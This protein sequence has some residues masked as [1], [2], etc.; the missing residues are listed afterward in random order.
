MSLSPADIISSANYAKAKKEFLSQTVETF[1]EKHKAW[2]L[3]DK[4]T[5]TGKKT[6]EDI[7]LGTSG[8]A[9][10]H[11]P[12]TRLPSASLDSETRLISLEDK[13]T[14]KNYR[15]TAVEDIID[16][17][18]TRMKL[19]THA[20]MAL[21]R[22]T[23][24]HTLQNIILGS[25]TN[26][27]SVRPAGIAPAAVSG[28]SISAAF[29]LSTNGSISIQDKLAEAKQLM[30]ERNVDI[31]EDDLYAFLPPY[32][33]RVLRKD[34]DLLNKDY[35]GPEFGN[36]LIRGKILKVEGWWVMEHNLIPDA[37]LS[38]D[39]SQPQKF[40]QY[41]YRGDYSNTAFCGMKLGGVHARVSPIRSW[42]EWE[43]SYQIWDIG[44]GFVKG[45]DIAR[46]EYCVEWAITGS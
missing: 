43:N 20:G 41:V 35:D 31:D 19:G 28:A 40:G 4:Q 1:Q 24:K 39:T 16:H 11:D 33:M 23:E 37:D 5:M 7:V 10:I 32:L 36:S 46:P 38:A 45:L 15:R 9:E 3:V 14:L 8:D 18:D 22:T 25:R 30:A 34:R 27:T 42:I 2:A 29:P 17:T 6:D 21:M 12:D 44:T 26:A 13:Q